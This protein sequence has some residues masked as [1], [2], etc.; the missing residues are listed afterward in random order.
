MAENE[1]PFLIENAGARG[2]TIFVCDHASNRIPER[3]GTLG[4][5]PKALSTH[6][7][8]DPGALGVARAMSRRLDG[9][10]IS[11]T[12]SRLVIDLNRPLRSAA[13]ITAVSETTQIPGNRDLA[14]AEREARVTHIYR[15]YHAAVDNLVGSVAAARDRDGEAL[16][17]V[18]AV[19]TFTPVYGGRS[20]PWHIGVLFGEDR[21]LGEPL[22]AELQRMADIRA[23]ANEPYSPADDVYWTLEYHA[24]ARG[25]P[26]VMIEIR[27]DQVA[28][29]SAQNAWGERLADALA[30]VMQARMTDWDLQRGFARA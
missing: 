1:A 30:R 25:L 24:V 18:V 12:V 15:P 4:L 13:L 26:S 17:A 14:P 27:N 22:L 11:A 8:W 6:I 23:A 10:L 9:P 5:S 28:D 7:A 3:L 29:E 16:P 21:R 2:Q 19:H 20:R